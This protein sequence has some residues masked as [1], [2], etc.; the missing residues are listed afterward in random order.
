[1]RSDQDHRPVINAL[2]IQ[3][4]SGEMVDDCGL[5]LVSA[6]VIALVVLVLLGMGGRM[7][8]LAV[9]SWGARVTS[10][11]DRDEHRESVGRFLE[12]ANLAFA[13]AQSRTGKINHLE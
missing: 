9:D 1:M 4:A 5:T 2:V 7:A 8:Y 12:S 10:K 6:A 13:L 11:S 3:G